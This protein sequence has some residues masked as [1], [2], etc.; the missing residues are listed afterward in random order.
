[1][2][3]LAVLASGDVM[4]AEARTNYLLYCS[5]CHRPT[6]EGKA[7][8]V[9]TLHDELGRMLA[10][11]AMRSYLFRIP[12]AAHT[13]LSDAELAAVINW[14]LTEFNAATLPGD[15]QPFTAE[16][17]ARWRQE[18]LADPLSYREQH[19]RAYD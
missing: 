17:V 18:I 14:V 13:P 15:F 8:N 9:P 3:L 6:G 4:A 16:Q 7:P 19:W 11:P 12:G 5:G 10:V 1:M 2:S